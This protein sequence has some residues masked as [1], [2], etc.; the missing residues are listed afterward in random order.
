MRNYART[1][2]RLVVLAAACMSAFGRVGKACDGGYD[3]GN[4]VT[5]DPSFIWDKI[6]AINDNAQIR[7]ILLRDD[8]PRKV[9]VGYDKSV[10]TNSNVALQVDGDEPEWLTI[11]GTSAPV[12]I[13]DKY[14]GFFDLTFIADD[15][16]GNNT[17]E[18]I[19]FNLIDKD[20]GDAV[21]LSKKFQVV[22]NK[23]LVAQI[24]KPYNESL[25]RADVPFYGYAYSTAGD[26]KVYRLRYGTNIN[27]VSW[28][29]FKTSTIQQRDETSKNDMGPGKALL[30]GNLGN[31]ST[32]L[33]E[34]GMGGEGFNG[35]LT[36]RLE[37]ED[38]AGNLVCDQIVVHVARLGT[39]GRDSSS[40]SADGRFELRLPAFASEYDYPLFAIGE[41][42]SNFDTARPTNFRV[43]KTYEV[44]PPGA[45]SHI[46]WRGSPTLSGNGQVGGGKEIADVP[47]SCLRKVKD[48]ESK[49]RGIRA[50]KRSR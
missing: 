27:P 20:N 43:G 3:C 12:D 37:V 1:Y 6:R 11:G 9:K 35:K 45:T 34:L 44:Q 31:L 14:L 47:R 30:T 5:C 23:T 4:E 21:L 33:S 2:C 48:G 19:T 29:T 38:T 17:G 32:G 10:F 28:V 40:A 36:I 50:W 22:V 8:E 42:A 41:F 26:F 18:I 25:V 46:I 16:V 15:D 39:L 49:Y 7:E 13:G 24:H